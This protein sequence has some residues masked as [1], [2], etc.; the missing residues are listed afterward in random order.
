MGDKGPKTRVEKNVI[1]KAVDDYRTQQAKA[2]QRTS[3]ADGRIDQVV[4][5]EDVQRIRKQK[6]ESKVKEVMMMAMQ[7]RE[8]EDEATLKELESLD[9]DDVKK[10]R[11]Q[12]IKEIHEQKKLLD[13][14]RKKNHGVVTSVVDQAE[15]FNHVKQSKFVVC[16]FFKT[17]NKWCDMMR[18]LL[19]KIAPLHLETRFLEM[20]GEK[21]PYLCEK[22]AIKVMPTI[23]LCKDNKIDRQCAGLD[24]FNPTGVIDAELVELRLAEW[25]FVVETYLD[26]PKAKKKLGITSNVAID[27]DSDS[28]LDI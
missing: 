21:A 23:V 5:K 28:D 1:E 24:P 19:K 18:N 25:G 8:D 22:L 2:P 10:L 13:Q 7:D 3:F 20:E 12:R 14:W 9:L 27:S 4:T 6:L 15:F 26:D 11:Q 16:I 17:A